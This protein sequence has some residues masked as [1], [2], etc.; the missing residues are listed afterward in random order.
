MQAFKFIYF[1]LVGLTLLGIVWA[2]GLDMEVER[3]TIEAQRNG[4]WDVSMGGAG[5]A[6]L[7]PIALAA[8]SYLIANLVGVVLLVLDRKRKL[9]KHF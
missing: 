5:M 8:L 1:F 9:L 7:G 3:Q 6:I 2:I 4:T